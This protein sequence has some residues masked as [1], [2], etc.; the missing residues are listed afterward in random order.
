MCHKQTSSELLTREKQLTP[1]TMTSNDIAYWPEIQE[2]RFLRQ[3][4]AGLSVPLVL[5]DPAS[6]VFHFDLFRPWD[7]RRSRDRRRLCRPSVPTS[8]H[9]SSLD[10]NY[11]DK[12]L[13]DSGQ[14]VQGQRQ[15]CPRRRPATY[16][17]HDQIKM[18]NF[19]W[20]RAYNRAS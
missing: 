17:H 10:Q 11:T 2:V 5:V 12:N 14:S 16:C 6:H 7:K 15:T 9:T 3:C 18:R 13:S 8:T 1:K 4:L 20:L 19:A